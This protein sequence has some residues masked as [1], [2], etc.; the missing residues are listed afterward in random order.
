MEGLQGVF[1]KC[2]ESYIS[3]QKILN[4]PRTCCLCE[5]CQKK[6]HSGKS[7]P[8]GKCPLASA[9]GKGTT[10]AHQRVSSVMLIMS[11]GCQRAASFFR[12]CFHED[13]GADDVITE[14][15]LTTAA[16]WQ[17][18]TEFARPWALGQHSGV[19]YRACAEIRGP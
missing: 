17:A 1:W 7:A 10:N 13:S 4:Q 11:E 15:P 3:C 2:A 12:C 8:D 14:T 5:S 6:C 19:V 16:G 9:L 18:C